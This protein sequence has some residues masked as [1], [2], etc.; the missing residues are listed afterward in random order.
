MSSTTELASGGKGLMSYYPP[1][2]QSGSYWQQGA[3]VGEVGTSQIS[4]EFGSV[5]QKRRQL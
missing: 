3:Q 1:S 4:G 2:T 5:L